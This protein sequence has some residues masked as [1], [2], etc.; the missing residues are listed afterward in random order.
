MGNYYM[1][2]VEQ[3]LWLCYL[4][5]YQEEYN[6]DLYL[7]L[8]KLREGV[9]LPI[10]LKEEA[11]GR[12]FFYEIGNKVPIQQIFDGV[13]D[14]NQFLKLCCKLVDAVLA[15]SRRGIPL[16]TLVW[17]LKG[18]FVEPDTFT[19]G[20]V[21]NIAGHKQNGVDGIKQMRDLLGEAKV[22]S[23][24]FAIQS[25]IEQYLNSES[26][27]SLEDFAIYLEQ[28]QR[29][30]SQK[31]E[32][33][34][35]LS[36]TSRLDEKGIHIGDFVEIVSLPENNLDEREDAYLIRNRN[37]ERIKIGKPQFYIGKEASTVDYCI[38]DNAA[39]SRSHAC[40]V[41]MD[42]HYFIKDLGSTN[43]TY[44]NNLQVLQNRLYELRKGYRIT[45]A[46]EVFYFQ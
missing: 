46:N 43:H 24:S 11:R 8:Q 23:S 33:S 5:S 39:I 27:H 17:S 32:Y 31:K 41:Y 37:G 45:L 16:S 34:G 29:Q 7:D 6:R 25:Q 12:I 9:I 44:V 4:C 2:K 28:L 1:H 42:K 14:E 30:F 13:L 15:I 35:H 36:L 3:R 19:P 21:L 22:T 38:E 10:T 18:I 40:I 26:S 20:W